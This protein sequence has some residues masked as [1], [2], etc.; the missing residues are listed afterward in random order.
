M[1]HVTGLTSLTGA[2]AEGIFIGCPLTP[3]MM[4]QKL[5]LEF[6]YDQI[7]ACT[8]IAAREGA[9]II[10]L[11]AFTSVVG[12]G[13]VTVAQRSPIAVTT[14]NSYTVATAIEGALKA[15]DLVGIQP[16]ES[17][18]A[19]VGATG[20]IGKTCA[21]VLAPKFQDTVVIGRD[22][23]RT[24]AV[25]QTLPRARAST[26]INDLL[27][28]D[29]VITVTSAETAIIAPEHLKRGSV[30][31]D[32]SRP[33]DTSVRVVTER[34][35][36]LVIEGGVVKVP[37]PVNFGMTFGFPPGTAYACMSE[38]MMLALED[39]IENFTLGKDV[40]VEQVEETNRLARKHGFEVAG[41]RAF[42]RGVDDA[43]IARCREARRELLQAGTSR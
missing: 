20:S 27:Q 26:D 6:V 10:G 12:D 14:G 28:A 42:E 34:P 36:V 13:G 1:A 17:K 25:A 31:C 23:P 33:R 41:F 38:T 22:L 43:A 30:V 8:E 24:E 21:V 11:G 19:V 7:V 5:P 37:G 16:S 2:T 35:D 18:L 39:R 9:K 3:L 29:L 40:S 32:V 15:C 4:T